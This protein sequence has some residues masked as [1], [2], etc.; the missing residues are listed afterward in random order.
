M[1]IV[2][3]C[4]CGKQLRARD[5]MAGRRGKCPGCARV[6]L[7]QAPTPAE[8][9]EDELFDVAPAPEPPPA[10]RRTAPLTA[11]AAVA[12]MTASRAGAVARPLPP[13]ASRASSAAAPP[14]AARAP[15]ATTLDP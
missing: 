4:E 2:V 5:E 10:V 8:P 6:L 3:N 14:L 12:P 13:I 1:S 7:I 15:T 9:A 11:A